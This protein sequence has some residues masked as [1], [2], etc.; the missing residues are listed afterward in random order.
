MPRNNNKDRK[1]QR[2]RRAAIRMRLHASNPHGCF[3]P[4]KH[5]DDEHHEMLKEAAR[6]E[7][8]Q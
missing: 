8:K 2:R 6:I 1:A 4:I 5:S 7:A 3:R